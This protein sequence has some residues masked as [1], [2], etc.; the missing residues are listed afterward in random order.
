MTQEQ[1]DGSAP[2]IFISYA[3]ADDDPP[4][5]AKFGWV[6]TLVEELK[7]ILRRKLGGPGASVWMDW[8]LTANDQ[9]TGTLVDTVRRSRTLVLFLSPGYMR[10]A[11][12]RQEL[13]DFLERHQTHKGRESVFIV[14]LDHTDRDTWHPRLKELTPIRFFKVGPD[15]IPLLAGFPV[16][17]PDQE[18]L[19]WQNLN[20][21]AYLVANHLRSAPRLTEPQSPGTDESARNPPSAASSGIGIKAIVWVAEPTDDLIDQWDLLAEGI[22]QTGAEI[23]PLGVDTYPRGSEAA[24]LDQLRPDL[25]QAHL[26]VQLLGQAP[27][28]RPKDGALSFT[29]LQSALAGETA[30]QNQL[31][32]L[33]WRSAEVKLE[34]ILDDN[35]RQLLTGAIASGFEEFRHRVLMAIEHLRQAPPAAGRPGRADDPLAICIS[36]HKTDR[37]LGL[38]IRDILVDL[39]A[40]ALAAPEAPAQNQKP[41]E[42]NAQLDEV[43]SGSQGVII[44]YGQTPPVWVQAQYIRARKALAQRRGGI[45]GAVLDGPPSEK[46]EHGIAGRNLMMLDC[47]E[48]PQRPHLE[49]FIDA[50]RESGDA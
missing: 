20:K 45:W 25:E 42:F 22:R 23:R 17:K 29:A 8:Q 48:G 10:S 37:D 1:A 16:P 34:S 35:Y 2:D 14:E 9:V 46:P 44:V 11:W 19:Y 27:G 28:R 31:P 49:R 5:G 38:R 24:F 26:F 33:R 36:A 18:D 40:D 7:K 3:H 15:G 4:E 12:C 6:T 13:G 21:L 47:R 41:T 30:A 50:L 43:M 32:F 39:G